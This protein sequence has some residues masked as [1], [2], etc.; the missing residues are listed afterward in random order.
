M[1]T[2]NTALEHCLGNGYRHLLHGRAGM[3][4]IR[5]DRLDHQE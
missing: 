4:I 2:A 3:R 5:G 1:F